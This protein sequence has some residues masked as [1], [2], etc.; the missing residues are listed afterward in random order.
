[1]AKEQDN[2]GTWLTPK[3]ATQALGISERTLRRH[4][5]EGRYPVRREGRHILIYVLGRWGV[6]A[7]PPTDALVLA[8]LERVVADHAEH[9]QRLQ[10]LDWLLR[11]MLHPLQ[12]LQRPRSLPTGAPAQPEPEQGST[13]KLRVYR[14]T[15]P[16]W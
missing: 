16:T 14:S 8:L 2:T 13:G 15:R 12:P 10:R 1:V 4:V 9:S 7:E 3:Q 11:R 6:P 5:R